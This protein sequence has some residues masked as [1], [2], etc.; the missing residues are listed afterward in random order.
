MRPTSLWHAW[1]QTAAADPSAVAIIEAR[2]GIAYSRDDLSI[3]AR[4]LARIA[5]ATLI[6]G[7][8]VA[9]AQG[10]GWRWLAKFLALQELGVPALPLDASLP[11]GQRSDAAAALGAH[12]LWLPSGD[13]QL[14]SRDL[15]PLRRRYLSHQN[16][17]RHHR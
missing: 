7:Q 1:E 10:N 12:W 16:D 5:P 8:V 15:P 3:A 17:L 13:W 9:F 6:P 14:L 2:D 11:P 4:S